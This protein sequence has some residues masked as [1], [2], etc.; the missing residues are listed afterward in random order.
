MRYRRDRTPG[1]CYFFTLVTMDRQ[2]LL[3]LPENLE[4]LQQGSSRKPTAFF[5]NCW[6][7]SCSNLS[8][9]SLTLDESGLDASLVST[10]KA[11]VSVTNPFPASGGKGA[12]T[13]Q[14][15]KD[16][17]LAYFQAQGRSVTREDY[18]TRV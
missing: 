10:V 6:T 15:L 12:E 14:Q 9:I 2:P 11:S 4:R 8:E 5:S 1:G 17:A 7:N 16:N 3:T 13:V 18:I